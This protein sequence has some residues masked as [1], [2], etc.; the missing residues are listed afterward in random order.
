MTPKEASLDMSKMK[1]GTHTFTV[2]HAGF[3]K[4][5]SV[6]VSSKSILSITILSDKTDFETGDLISNLTIRVN[7][8]NGTYEDV[9]STSSDVKITL[10]GT[11]TANRKLVETDTSYWVTYKEIY[12]DHRDITVCASPL[13]SSV[14]PIPTSSP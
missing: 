12:T 14:P 9:L 1:A 10:N 6:D 5:F 11:T 3:T 8:D 7:Y 4:E 2:S 13:T